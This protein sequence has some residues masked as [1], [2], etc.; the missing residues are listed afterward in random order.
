M[1]VAII[2]LRSIPGQSAINA[3]V[4]VILMIVA[5]GRKDSTLSLIGH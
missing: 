1:V 3:V 5:V 4:L 2:A